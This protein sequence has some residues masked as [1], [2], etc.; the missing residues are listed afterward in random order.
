MAPKSS[1]GET[2]DGSS[3]ETEA[4]EISTGS[5]LGKRK[6]ESEE[7][8]DSSWGKDSFDGREYHSSDDMEEYSSDEYERRNRFYRRTVIETKGFFES[9]CKFPRYLWYGIV[10]ISDLEKEVHQ[11]VSCRQFLANMACECLEKYNKKNNKGFNVKFDRIL[12]A[13]FNPSSTTKYYITFAAR[14]SDSPDA[15]LVEYQAKAARRAGKTYPILCRPSPPK[16][17]DHLR[18]DGGDQLKE[19]AKVTEEIS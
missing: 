17:H 11:G 6:V 10:K 12:R 15:P 4:M 14:E 19:V 3:K 9:C 1:D 8:S 7:D 5:L 16:T 18:G 13:N 2:N